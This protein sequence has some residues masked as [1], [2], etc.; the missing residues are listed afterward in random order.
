MCDQGF[1]WVTVDQISS[2]LGEGLT[3]L[4]LHPRIQPCLWQGMVRWSD[5]K[6]LLLFNRFDRQTLSPVYREERPC[7][8]SV[9]Q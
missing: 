2:Y 1:D 9:R 4:S 3:S 5:T 8:V 6:L 7:A